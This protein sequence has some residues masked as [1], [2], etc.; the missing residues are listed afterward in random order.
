MY[1]AAF[2]LFGVSQL[3]FFYLRVSSTA[4]LSL[5]PFAEAGLSRLDLRDL[6]SVIAA[7]RAT[8]K[9][10]QQQTDVVVRASS[11]W[12]DEERQEV[13]A[14]LI[15]S[16]QGTL[17]DTFLASIEGKYGAAVATQTTNRELR[18][19]CHESKQRLQLEIDVLTRR[20]NINLVI[21][22]ITTLLA[23]GLLAYVVLSETLSSNDVGMV[24]LHFLP[25]LSI[26]VFIETFSFFFLRLYRSGLNDIKY[27]QNELTNIE[28]KHLVLESLVGGVILDQAKEILTELAKTDRNNVVAKTPAVESKAAPSVRD[29]E[30]LIGK[31][32]DLAGK[33]SS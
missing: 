18:A 8:V 29:V 28:T 14:T 12:T 3:L 10:L 21:G 4:S 11:V 6:G 9:S 30:G 26:V 2:V 19:I 7:L 23:V 32:T 24:L 33:L 20:S 25:R 16:V 1:S 22:V 15:E 17:S 31:I 13:V 5:Q 27:Y